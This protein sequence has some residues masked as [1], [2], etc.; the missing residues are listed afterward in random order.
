[1]VEQLESRVLGIEQWQEELIS[2]MNKLLDLM[3][4]KGKTVPPQNVEEESNPTYPRGFTPLHGQTSTQPP[5]VAENPPP[6]SASFIPTA[7]TLGVPAVGIPPTMM[8]DVGAD[9]IATKRRYEVLKEWLRATE[10]SNSFDTVDLIDLYLVLKVTLPLKFKMPDFEKYNGTRCPHAHLL[11]Y[12]QAM[13]AYSDNEKLIDALLPEPFD[14]IY[15]PMEMEKKPTETFKEY[16]YRWRNMAI[17]VDPPVSEREAISLFVGTLK[18]PYRM[19][20][21][22]ATPHDFMDVVPTR[23]RIE[24]NIKAS[25]VRDGVN[26]ASLGKRWMGRKK[27]EE[28]HMVQ[29]HYYQGGGNRW[30]KR[31]F[32]F[33]PPVNQV[34]QT[35]ARLQRAPPEPMSA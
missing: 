12:C 18:N 4:D 15:H 5:I 27:D 3:M 26:E 10:G 8:T 29:G 17:Q 1:M 2:K 22:R 11:I 31:N 6:K 9:R 34:A 35:G 14:R 32:F 21:R 33:G 30:P 7:P 13:A 19:H 20:L 28:T 25:L 24:A 23:G 16:A